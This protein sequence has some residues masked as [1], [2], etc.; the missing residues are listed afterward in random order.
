MIYFLVLFITVIP[1]FLIEEGILVCLKYKNNILN[2]LWTIDIFIFV[3]IGISRSMEV[4]IDLK[5]Y[6]YYFDSNYRFFESGYVILTDLVRNF[7]DN[8]ILLRN[9]L[10]FVIPLSYG[11]VVFSISKKKWLSSLL[12]QALYLFVSSFSLLRQFIAISIVLVSLLMLKQYLENKRL[13]RVK[14]LFSVILILIGSFFHYSALAMII[15]PII[16]LIERRYYLILIYFFVGL[17][18]FIFKD[19]IIQ[20]ML[21]TFFP[22]KHY[23][24]NFQPEIGIF[25]ILQF[26]LIILNQFLYRIKSCEDEF[27]EQEQEYLFFTNLSIVWFITIFIFSWFP[28]LARITMYV[29]MSAVVFLPNFMKYK[30]STYLIII[31]VLTIYYI[32]AL[33]YRDY[34][35]VFPYHFIWGKVL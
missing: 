7:S 31:I 18:L 6:L 16:S 17:V 30:K 33:F 25:P 24:S 5:A 22:T 9:I 3:I 2:L 8:F 19:S 1:L 11:I 12:F 34:Q 23:Y 13:N 20:F 35:G 26:S 21:T 14:L 10:A 4:G 32:F 29:S 15:L 27:S 28:N